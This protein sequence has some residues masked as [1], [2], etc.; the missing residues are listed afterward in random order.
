MNF[1]NINWLKV[2]N[3]SSPRE[4]TPAQFSQ[5]I[6]QSALELAKLAETFREIEFPYMAIPENQR[7]PD[8]LADLFSALIKNKE[9]KE[10]ES[11]FTKNPPPKKQAFRII[12]SIFGT[13]RDDEEKKFRTEQKGTPEDVTK[14]NVIKH[15]NK[16]KEL[17]VP[18]NLAQQYYQRQFEFYSDEVKELKITSSATRAV[19]RVINFLIP[20]EMLTCG[21]V[22]VVRERL[23]DIYSR[24]LSLT[25]NVANEIVL[26]IFVGRDIFDSTKNALHPVISDVIS[27][28]A[29]NYL[30]YFKAIQK[31][32]SLLL[33]DEPFIVTASP[34]TL[35]K[36]QAKVKE[37]LIPDIEREVPSPRM[38]G[39][40]SK[41]PKKLETE[42]IRPVIWHTERNVV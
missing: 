16:I 37:E 13:T 22:H 36:I 5:Q 39:F 12:T 15:L 2:I 23:I 42:E 31:D 17:S 21:S 24:N 40:F 14:E 28:I 34:I 26:A 6:K 19:D 25:Q 32:S 35:E 9:Q 38:G 18:Q 27:S 8:V 7:R 29:E 30:C 20:L 11:I 41:T 1:K 4:F 10:I 33:E 3:M